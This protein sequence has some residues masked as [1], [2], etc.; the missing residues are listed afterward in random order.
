MESLEVQQSS[1]PQFQNLNV[2]MYSGA[3]SVAGAD[4]INV[5]RR[6]SADPHSPPNRRHA[7]CS[8][9]TTQ[10]QHETVGT[11]EA[12][13]Q[14]PPQQQP[15]S[16]SW[17]SQQQHPISNA[18]YASHAIPVA[19]ASSPTHSN[20]VFSNSNPQ[21]MHNSG[22]YTQPGY[23]VDATM[24][25][26]GPYAHSQPV[27]QPQAPIM[28]DAQATYAN[29][30]A[31]SGFDHYMPPPSEHK[32]REGKASAAPA[33]SKEPASSSPSAPEKKKV[34]NTLRNRIMEG[35]GLVTIREM[36]PITILVSGLL[37]HHFQHRQKPGLEPYKPPNWVRYAKNAMWVYSTYKTAQNNGIVKKNDAAP[38]APKPATR[39]ISLD[40][41]I[42]GRP[43]PSS[44]YGSSYPGGDRS[45]DLSEGPHSVAYEDN[46]NYSKL[47]MMESIV[48]ELFSGGIFGNMA[49][50]TSRGLD[51]CSNS[52]LDNFDDSWAVPKP[53]AE[54]YYRCIYHKS[55]S[56]DGVETHILGGAAAI[57]ALRNVK[58]MSGN[59]QIYSGTDDQSSYMAMSLALEEVEALLNRKAATAPLYLNDNM[60]H[61]GKIALAT[62]IKIKA[63][64]EPIP[65]ASHS[66]SRN[67]FVEASAYENNAYGYNLYKTNPYYRDYPT[68]DTGYT[69]AKP[70]YQQHPYQPHY[71]Q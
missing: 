58:I 48:G 52:L 62:I 9:L 13:L 24:T 69:E 61:A 64:E 28:A 30:Y 27:P 12:A 26:T 41:N 45:R 21:P 68:R 29:T 23:G 57:N 33:S 31:N 1:Q 15:H 65:Y 51:G 8:E 10:P 53:L 67:S 55:Q 7:S 38:A 66:E 17:Y 47:Q 6:Q 5:V 37:A 20:T 46:V 59:G 11:R 60:E 44:F 25:D 16:Q 22:G 3:Q 18:S 63:E 32:S 19:N 2:S 14:Q 56:L 35:I 36:A 54:E 42:K 71:W 70:N 49:D 4:Q 50:T 40:N 43:M 34:A 39:G